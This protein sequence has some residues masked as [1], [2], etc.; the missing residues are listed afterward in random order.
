VYVPAVA[1]EPHPKLRRLERHVRIAEPFWKVSIFNY[2]KTQLLK[3]PWDA[4]TYL[5]L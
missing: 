2:M 4:L 5:L 3:E 1:D